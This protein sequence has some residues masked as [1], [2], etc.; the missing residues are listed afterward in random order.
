MCSSRKYTSYPRESLWNIPNSLGEGFPKPKCFDKTIN[1]KLNWNFQER[2]LNEK[3]FQSLHVNNYY[4]YL[5]W[6]F[7]FIMINPCKFNRVVIVSQTVLPDNKTIL[8][9]LMEFG[10][11][12][13][14]IYHH[15]ENENCNI[16][17]TTW[18]KTWI[19]IRS[20]IYW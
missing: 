20:L 10:C 18:L 5:L 4:F 13:V 9:S 7:L 14:S 11:H 16:L 17:T 19:F 2:G 6:L 8:N 12:S 15:C 1:Y 3:N